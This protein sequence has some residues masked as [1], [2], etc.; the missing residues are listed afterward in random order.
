[1]STCLIRQEKRQVPSTRNFLKSNIETL[2]GFAVQQD[3]V[4][5]F[6]S[7]PEAKHLENTGL[8][9]V[10]LKL[11]V[12]EQGRDDL[13]NRLVRRYLVET[14]CGENE[15]STNLPCIV[16]SEQTRRT[17]RVRFSS[18]LRDSC[19]CFSRLL[20]KIVQKPNMVARLI[21]MVILRRLCSEKLVQLLTESTTV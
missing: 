18:N 16:V 14:G 2:L 20:A 9:A 15:P 7:R 17:E 6:C 19:L 3:L 5:V 13:I 21:A 12:F 1:M 4:D 11:H 10:D 8:V